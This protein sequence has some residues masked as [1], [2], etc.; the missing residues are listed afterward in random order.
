VLLFGINELVELDV[1]LLNKSKLNVVPAV[2]F[3][4]SPVICIEAFSEFVNP[5]DEYE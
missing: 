3:P 5:V 1:E 4:K 2:V